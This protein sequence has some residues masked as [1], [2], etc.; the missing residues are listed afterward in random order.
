MTKKLKVGLFG[1][2]GCAGCLLTF[3]YEEC[4]REITNLVDVKAFPLIKEEDYKGDFDYVF[5][6]GTVCFDSDIVTLNE[7]RKRAK[8]VVAF[9]SCACV[10]GVPSIKNFLDSEKTMR[11]VYPVFNHLKSE[12][13]TPIDMH[14]K[15]DHYLPQCPPSK[16]ELVDFVQCIAQGRDF[17]AHRDPV[18]Y[19]CRRL[20]N[21]CL[22][23][24]GEIC[25]G[26]ITNG[27]CNALCPTNSTECYGCRGPCKDANIKSYLEMLK[28]MG[29]SEK[30]MHDKMSTFAGIQFKEQEGKHSEWLDK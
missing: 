26:P 23:D 29:Y 13:P 21:P 12:P 22:L 4:F 24:K 16:E 20:G 3:I 28:H 8:H 10:G 7:L 11:H 9:G 6:E 18:C 17:K 2:S 25:L 15:V 27:G 1:I 30:N 19:E 5:I 14:I